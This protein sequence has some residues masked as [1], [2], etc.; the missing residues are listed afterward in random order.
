MNSH[1][2]SWQ[3][4]GATSQ[5]WRLRSNVFIPFRNDLDNCTEVDRLQ[6]IL[7][8]ILDYWTTDCSG[9][10][11]T[12]KGLTLIRPISYCGIA[13][14][15]TPDATTSALQDGSKGSHGES[16]RKR[17]SGSA[18][19][20]VG[21]SGKTQIY[22]QHRWLNTIWIHVFLLTRNTINVAVTFSPTGCEHDREF[23]I[24][25]VQETE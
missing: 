7:W 20:V 23:G 18:P 22:P 3:S 8:T 14:P 6:R 15:L 1:P 25:S 16:E 13:K 5:Q 19:A 17:S 11:Q 2:R 10:C 24:H 9:F 21:G 12:N 4:G